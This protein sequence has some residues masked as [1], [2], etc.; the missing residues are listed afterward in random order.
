VENLNVAARQGYTPNRC[1]IQAT[2]ACE[3]GVPS[4]AS[5]VASSRE[6][7]CVAPKLPRTASD[8]GLSA[9]DT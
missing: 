5:A 3:I 1:Q 6:D 9:Y 7:Q 4:P 2:V 8:S